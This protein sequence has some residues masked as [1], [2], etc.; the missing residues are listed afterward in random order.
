MKN[1][2]IRWTQHTW[3]WCR[4]CTKEGAPCTNCY[5]AMMTARFSKSGQYGEG[6][7]FFDRNGQAQWTGRVNVVESKLREPLSWRD[8]ALVFV[9]SMSDSFHVDVEDHHL[10]TA[11][12][13]MRTASRH[14]FQVLTKRADRM[15]AFFHQHGPVPDNVW[16]GVSVG[17]RRAL[18]KLI[19]L[20]EIPAMVRWISAEPLIE[21]LAPTANDYRELVRLLQPVQWVVIGG[22]SGPGARPMRPE[23]ARK[24]RDAAREAGCRIFFKQM[25]MYDHDGIR[26]QSKHFDGFDLLDGERIMEY[27]RGYTPSVDLMG[28]HGGTAGLTTAMPTPTSTPKLHIVDDD[29]P[30][31]TQSQTAA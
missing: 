14:T 3:N 24:L 9:N 29:D 23:W 30:P 18:T 8:P 4:G 31:P 7:A 26:H 28:K 20:A 5:A 12:Q 11:F 15:A 25:G 6:L 27:P 1:T 19:T 17:D 13:T 22:E 16:C 2:G 10:L 21:D